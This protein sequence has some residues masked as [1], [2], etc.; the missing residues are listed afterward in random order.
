V[1][2]IPASH[3]L[4]VLS[5][6]LY[7]AARELEESQLQLSEPEIP[8]EP[9]DPVREAAAGCNHIFVAE[10]RECLNGCGARREVADGRATH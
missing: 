9:S 8:V 3:V 5:K 10:E 4:K 6:Y 1:T 7:L 2:E